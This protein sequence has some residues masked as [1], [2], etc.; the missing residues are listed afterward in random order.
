[1]GKD[2]QARFQMAEDAELERL[3]RA[4][5]FDTT[6]CQSVPAKK[7]L[8]EFLEKASDLLET[9]YQAVAQRQQQLL[10]AVCF[11]EDKLSRTGQ[12]H[13]KSLSQTAK[14]LKIPNTRK[15][16][17]ISKILT[18]LEQK[19]QAEEENRK[20]TNAIERIDS[21]N[22]ELAQLVHQLR[23]TLSDYVSNQENIEQKT[24]E[25]RE[26]DLVL[27][28]KCQDYQ[29][30]IEGFQEEYETRGIDKNGIRYGQLEE[31]K[32][33]NEDMKQQLGVYETEIR[34]FK[35]LPPDLS[36]A[37]LKL[38]EEKQRLAELELQRKTRLGKIGSIY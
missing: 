35:N 33:Q 15:F 36:L 7:D 23:D 4:A 32:R 12:A 25:W 16:S 5:E 38:A 22:A 21:R 6:L 30:R 28:K 8:D 31:L 13:L 19:Q 27:Q 34:A 9:E 17:F 20:L 14:L 11:S 1:M 3:L 29:K 10:E 37:K 26:S 2:C 24:L 18:L